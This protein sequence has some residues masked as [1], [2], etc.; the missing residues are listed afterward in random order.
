MLG[1]R[2]EFL[3]QNY[4]CEVYATKNRLVKTLQDDSINS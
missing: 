1:Y 2:L 3:L 4:L